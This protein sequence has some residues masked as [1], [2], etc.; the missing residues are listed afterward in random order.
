MGF[1][2]YKYRRISETPNWKTVPLN[3]VHPE[4][5]KPDEMRP[6]ISLSPILKLVESRFREKLE[7]HMTEKMTPCQVGF[8]RECGTHVNIVRLIRRCL[9]SYINNQKKFKPKVIL[10]IDF[11]SAYNNVNLDMLFQSLEQNKILENDETAFLRTLYSKTNLTIGKQ[12]CKD[13]L[14]V[15]FNIFIEDLLKKLSIEFNIEDVFG[16]ADDIVVC[17]YSM[18]QL[19]KAVEIIEEWSNK[20][21]IPINYKK[22]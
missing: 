16:Y 18:N 4:I 14:L 19:R 5:S 20:A 6:I 10:F 11:K 15:L 9:S 8:V 22:S 2:Y 3:K 13:L 21:G 7:R 17:I 12:L 1:K